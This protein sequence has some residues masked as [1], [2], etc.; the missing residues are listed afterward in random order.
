VPERDVPALAECIDEILSLDERDY[1]QLSSAARS[2]V[3]TSADSRSSARDL[4]AI[5]EEALRPQ[6]ASV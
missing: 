4:F 1:L 2:H 6:S 5:F 3:E